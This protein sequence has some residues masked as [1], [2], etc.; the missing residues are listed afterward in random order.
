MINIHNIM[1]CRANM[2]IVKLPSRFVSEHY[3]R[4]RQCTPI[5][6]IFIRNYANVIRITGVL[7]YD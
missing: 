4:L 3:G 1:K 2:H 6:G 7:N 5:E